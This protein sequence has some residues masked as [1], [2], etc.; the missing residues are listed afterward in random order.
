MYE[1]CP[2]LLTLSLRLPSDGDTPVEVAC[3]ILVNNNISSAP[4]FK[5]PDHSTPTIHSGKSYIGCIDYADIIAY[6]L[7]VLQ[8]STADESGSLGIQDI[9]KRALQGQSVPVSMAS[10]NNSPNSF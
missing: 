6:L 3:S 8:S 7:V 5:R 1:S 10:G 2:T 4:V 9:V